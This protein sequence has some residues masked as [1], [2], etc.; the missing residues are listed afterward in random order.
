MGEIK[1]DLAQKFTRSPAMNTAALILKGALSKILGFPIGRSTIA[2]SFSE[3]ANDSDII[4][5][6]I[7]VKTGKEEAPTAA[8]LSNIV[9]EANAKIAEDVTCNSFLLSRAEAESLYGD[10]MYDKYEVILT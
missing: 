2:T 1:I 6:K 9:E 5:G 3:S 7:T 4:K 8:E 10:T